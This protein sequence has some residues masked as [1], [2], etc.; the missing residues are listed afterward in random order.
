MRVFN[1]KILDP[2]VSLDRPKIDINELLYSYA[3]TPN[4]ELCIMHFFIHFLPNLIF[5]TLKNNPKKR[6]LKKICNNMYAAIILCNVIGRKKKIVCNSNQVWFKSNE[7]FFFV[8]V[9]KRRKVIKGDDLWLWFS[10]SIK[11]ILNCNSKI[12]P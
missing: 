4:I 9:L 11:K 5:F 10:F 7:N 1:Y 3:V 6:S 2:K 8:F 12:F